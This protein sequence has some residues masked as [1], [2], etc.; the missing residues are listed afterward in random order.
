MPTSRAAFLE[1]A[2]TSGVAIQPLPGN[3]PALQ[4][5]PDQVLADHLRSARAHYLAAQ[6]A[7]RAG[8]LADARGEL[9]EAEQLDPGLPFASPGAVRALQAEL[10]LGPAS[11][12]GLA[13]A[14]LEQSV[15]RFPGILLAGLGL[16]VQS[17]VRRRDAALR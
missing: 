8:R 11:E 5:V 4:Q 13:L 1:R 7:A 16:I 12:D 14:P 15:R 17:I 10:G 2:A 6:L 9:D 3:D